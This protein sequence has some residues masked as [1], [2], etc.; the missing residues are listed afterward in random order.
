M[1]V[2]VYGGGLFFE[3]FQQKAPARPPEATPITHMYSC[4]IL[5]PEAGLAIQFGSGPPRRFWLVEQL[6][7]IGFGLLHRLSCSQVGLGAGL[8]L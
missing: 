3:L 4:V 8:G 5:S 1:K 2:A 7:Q 6:E